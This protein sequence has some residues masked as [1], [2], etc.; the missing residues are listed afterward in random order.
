MAGDQSQNTTSEKKHI[1]Y[2]ENFGIKYKTISVQNK[3]FSAKYKV[4]TKNLTIGEL[5]WD[6]NKNDKTYKLN[7]ELKS[8]GF[9]SSVFKFSGS[10]TVSGFLKDGAYIPHH[11]RQEWL[12]KKR[13]R[14][15]QIAFI[16]NE[17][18]QVEH[19]KPYQHESGTWITRLYAS[20]FPNC[21]QAQFLSVN[22]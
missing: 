4:S 22:T 15:V 21:W 18:G 17:V 16:K 2:Q 19:L 8:K 5:F 12:T 3:N 7:I 6:L 9:L 10:Y 1:I 14:D 13:K 11:Y 20:N